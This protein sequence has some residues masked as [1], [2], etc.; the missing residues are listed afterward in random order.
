MLMEIRCDKFISNG[1]PRGPIEFHPGLNVILGD[2]NG[3]NSIGKSTFLMILDFVFGG[4]DYIKKSKD[5]QENVGEHNICFSFDFDGKKYYFCRNTVHYMQVQECDEKYQPLAN[6]EPLS[7]DAYCNFLM[8]KYKINI[9][10]STWRG[11]VSRFIRVYKRDTLDEAHPL[12]SAQQE[13]AELAIKS[14]MKLWGRYEVVEKQINAAN[15]AIEERDAFNKA[16]KYNQIRSARNKT[17][18]EDNNKRIKSLQ[19]KEQELAESSNKGLLNLD[20]MQAQR[21]SELKT[22]IIQFQREAAQVSYDLNNIRRDMTGEKK[23]FSKDFGELE[24]FFPNEDFR[25]LEEIEVFHHHLSKVLHDEYREAE[26]KLEISYVT[27]NG[28]IVKLKEEIASIKKIPNVSAAI[29]KEYAKIMTELNNLQEA[30]KNYEEHERLNKVAKEYT[31]NRDSVIKD[32]LSA[33]QMAVNQE[34]R[35]ITDQILGRG[36]QSP[37]LKLEGL[38][39]YSFET[40]NDGGTG[41]QFR[42]I[43]TF[44][45]ANLK[46]TTLPFI[47]HDSV[48]LKNLSK[49]TLAKIVK[50]YVSFSSREGMEKKQIFISYDSLDSYDEDTEQIM[51]KHAVLELSPD[52]NELF[53]WPWNKETGT[54]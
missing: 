15:E 24:H 26:R 14:F 45:L 25:S 28:E 44:D 12:K 3:S 5:V 41:A 27:L 52:G 47:I 34:M 30:N 35:L 33:I 32:Q 19:T 10:C 37:R 17:E 18:F 50:Q 31:E 20:G 11:A 39:K 4:K 49:D 22:Q 53:G 8:D 54:K 46:L 23:R 2:D 40:P 51:K 29:L 6:T 48:V 9:E 43:I 7:L 16:Q 38:T 36:K 13:K 42:G 21:L 1:H